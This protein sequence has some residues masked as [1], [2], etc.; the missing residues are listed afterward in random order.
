MFLLLD[1]AKIRNLFHSAI[2]LMNV[3]IKMIKVYSLLLIKL[4]TH[5]VFD[6]VVLAWSAS[7]DRAGGYVDGLLTVS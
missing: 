5:S 1:T 4:V 7:K 2:I 3:F 6:V